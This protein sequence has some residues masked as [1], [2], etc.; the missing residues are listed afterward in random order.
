MEA[1]WSRAP[2]DA[3]H[4]GGETKTYSACWYKKV[5]S[6]WYFQKARPRQPWYPMDN[7]P[8]KNRF[9]RMELRP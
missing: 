8:T 1:D 3:T 2:A 7:P 4:F 5:G 6:T 9:G